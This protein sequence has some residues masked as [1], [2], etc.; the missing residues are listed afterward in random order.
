METRDL[1]EILGLNLES[2]KV[3]EFLQANGIFED[4]VSDDDI[5][6][7]SY[8]LGVD[9]L[10]KSKELDSIFLYTSGK[11]GHKKYGGSIPIGMDF[12]FSREEL[13][14]SHQPERSWKIGLGEVEKAY[15]NPSHDRWVLGKHSI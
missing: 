11:D 15:P 8:E 2:N 5:Y 13:I 4:Y 10:F 9:L 7:I 3:Q 6:K 12:S 1:I 14:F